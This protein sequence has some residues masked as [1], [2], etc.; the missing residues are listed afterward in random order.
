MKRHSIHSIIQTVQLLTSDSI[1][2]QLNGNKKCYTRNFQRITRAAV[3]E[4]LR[5]EADDITE[6]VQQKIDLMDEICANLKSMEK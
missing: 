6:A 5:L 2:N 3:N 1:T 4:I